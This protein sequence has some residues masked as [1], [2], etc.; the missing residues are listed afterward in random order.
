[1]IQAPTWITVSI[2]RFKVSY[3]FTTHLEMEINRNMNIDGLDLEKMTILRGRAGTGKTIALIKKAIN[4][5]DN[6]NSRVLLLTYNKALVS[7]IMRLFA[8]AD[9]PDMF[10]PSCVSINTMHAFFY[11]IINAGLYSGSLSGDEFL[12]TYD[13]KMEELKMYL[14]DADVKGDLLKLLERDA[15]LNWDYCFVDEAQDWS[16]VERDVLLQLFENN[17]FIADGG[18]QFVRSMDGCDWN[19]V[20]NRSNI[21]L[22]KSLRQEN[23]IITFI[24]CLVEKI[25]PD[26]TPL[27]PN[28]VMPGGRVIIQEADL[29]DTMNII[30]DE[31]ALLKKTGNIEYD[32][33]MFVPH[34]YVDDKD[35]GL[36][37][38]SDFNRNDIVVWDGTRESV[39]ETYSPIGD[40]IR[41]LQYES[42][43]GL[44]GWSVICFELD[45][46][47]ESK[48]EKYIPEDKESLML[49]SDAERKMRYCWD[50]RIMHY[51]LS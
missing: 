39:R 10:Q 15:Y 20:S 43:R 24:N 26:Y 33:L 4:I 1:M 51:R 16:P 40:E 9:L 12:N 11:R 42:G 46:F 18:N 48:M 50:R 30:K 21:K 2:V 29:Q 22:K 25:Y 13:A 23:N 37:Y 6:D 34:S 36:K 3:L 14:E 31:R 19:V 44:E 41:V 27:P 17:L 49:Q 7:D 35:A 38:Y 32:M 28:E 8:L 5:V 47:I 45:T